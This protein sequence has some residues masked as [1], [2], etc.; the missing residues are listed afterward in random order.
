MKKSLHLFA[1]SA[2]MVACSLSASAQFSPQGVKTLEANFHIDQ[3]NNYELFSSG[4]SIITMT[5]DRNSSSQI[6]GMS[7]TWNPLFGDKQNKT[8]SSVNG[9]VTYYNNQIIDSGNGIT[10][11]STETREIFESDGS[12]D[13]TV[14]TVEYDPA[15]GIMESIDKEQISYQANGNL[16][17]IKVYSRAD[18]NDVFVL[19]ET[20]H[21]F[22]N[23]NNVLDSTHTQA[24]N[25]SV[26]ESSIYY[27]SASK[28][29]SVYYYSTQQ[30]NGRQLM[31]MGYFSYSNG[32]TVLDLYSDDDQ[33][34]NFTF[35]GRWTFNAGATGIEE[36]SQRSISLYPNPSQGSITIE[37]NIQDD[38][39]VLN[40]LGAVV[41]SGTLVSGQNTLNMEHLSPGCYVIKTMKASTTSKFILGH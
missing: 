21:F 1:I 37:S 7:G 39:L 22:Y 2:C 23:A 34:G 30:G 8:T 38:Y 18:S 13:T 6:V 17:Q 3:I 14:T 15:T 36:Q 28:I 10:S 20:L 31:Q 9:N 32:S 27:T 35:E 25:G 19:D 41:A 33:D 5:V 11:F 40:Q 24:S 29:D 16:D 4:L 26:Y 12:R